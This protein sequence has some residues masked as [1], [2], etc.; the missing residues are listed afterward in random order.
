MTTQSFIYTAGSTYEWTVINGIITEDDGE[1]AITVEWIEVGVGSVSV[2]KTTQDGCVQP[3]VFLNVNV[4]HIISVNELASIGRRMYPNPATHQV[5]YEVHGFDFT[6]LRIIDAQ[7]RL[8]HATST[9][10]SRYFDVSGLAAG[11]YVVH[12]VT[13]DRIYTQRLM[14]SH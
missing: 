14:V 8:V 7:G 5:F 13:S 6:E 3:E 12:F 1:A 9:T 11:H 4:E 2:V 10:G